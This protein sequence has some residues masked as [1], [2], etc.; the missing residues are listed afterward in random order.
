MLQNARETNIK[1]SLNRLKNRRKKP[2]FPQPKNIPQQD[3][4]TPLNWGV[5]ALYGRPV[6]DQVGISVGTNVGAFVG[7]S[8]AAVAQPELPGAPTFITRTA[9]NNAII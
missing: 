1:Y 7:A 8:V 9:N 2:H 3:K 5:G 6:G 4:C